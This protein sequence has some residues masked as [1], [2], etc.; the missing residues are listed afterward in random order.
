M[1]PPATIAQAIGDTVALIREEHE[2]TLDQVARASRTYGATWSASSV[3]NIEMGKAA[4]SL[5]NLLSL[6]LALGD[7]THSEL[8]IADLLG[9]AECFAIPSWQGEYPVKREA[10]LRILGNEPVRLDFAEDFVGSQAVLSSAIVELLNAASEFKVRT[11]DTLG[12]HKSEVPKDMHPARMGEI[13]ER[14]VS[15]AEER[16]AEKL[17]VWTG[18]VQIWAESLW[19]QSLE[20]EAA[21]RAAA[22]A[23][24]FHKQ[25]SPQIRGAMTRKLIKEMQEAL[26]RRRREVGELDG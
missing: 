1:Q 19:N 20:E 11:A 5:P 4:T 24:E 14:P 2:L 7:L 9:N 26:E 8:S 25:V 12:F 18:Q 3:R 15:L 17:K 10:I 23:H 13:L 21:E 22:H 16:A 6:A